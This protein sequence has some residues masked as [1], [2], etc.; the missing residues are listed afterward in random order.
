MAK[1]VKIYQSGLGKS[2]LAGSMVSI[3]VG[4]EVATMTAGEWSKL[5]ANPERRDI[6]ATERNVGD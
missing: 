4:A 6:L 1:E 2:L 5:I 3:R